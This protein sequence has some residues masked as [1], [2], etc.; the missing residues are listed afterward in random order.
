MK[1]INISIN[2]NLT[3]SFLFFSLIGFLDAVYLTTEDYLNQSVICILT[4]GCQNVLTSQYSQ[5]FGVP[6]A[7]FGVIYYLIIIFCS[8]SYLTNR[9][10]L[11]NYLLNYFTSVG[12]LVSL[13]LVYLQL[14]VIKAICFYCM[15]SALTSTILFILSLYLILNHKKYVQ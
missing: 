6:L 8:L 15:I 12:F 10:N 3:C 2:K 5:I 9:N 14:F 13:Y 7:L 1:L 4:S 11:A